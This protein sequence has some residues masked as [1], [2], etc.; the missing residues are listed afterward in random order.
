MKVK[1]KNYLNNIKEFDVQL[2]EDTS[3]LVIVYT[4]L[5]D[6]EVV[7]IFDNNIKLY[8][9]DSF[10]SNEFARTFDILDTIKLI[11]LDELAHLN[12]EI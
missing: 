8:C 7:Y 4:K 9:L 12:Q 11:T 10:E 2:P 5:V 1:L 3:H 6:D